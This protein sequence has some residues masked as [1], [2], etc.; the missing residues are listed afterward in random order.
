MGVWKL[1]SA[2]TKASNGSLATLRRKNGLPVRVPEMEAE[3]CG[4]R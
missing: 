2:L 1:H 4:C 3:H